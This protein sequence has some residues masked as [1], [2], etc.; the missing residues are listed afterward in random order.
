MVVSALSADEA[1]G[2]AVS[3][4][5]S[6]VFEM[7][8]T[9]DEGFEWRFIGANVFKSW[10]EEPGAMDPGSWEIVVARIDDGPNPSTASRFAI[11]GRRIEPTM[12]PDAWG[13]GRDVQEKVSALVE[14]KALAAVASG[15]GDRPKRKI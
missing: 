6:L 10:M 12:S 13:F 14:R 7:D 3:F 1:E 9:V 4:A 5:G 15:N 11:E 2:A 8:K